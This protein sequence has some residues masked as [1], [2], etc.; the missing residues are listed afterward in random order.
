[1]SYFLW[2]RELKPWLLPQYP[3]VNNCVPLALR[4]PMS[5]EVW[6]QH[7][8]VPPH[9]LPCIEYCAFSVENTGYNSQ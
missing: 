2:I 4:G 9:L 3:K 1:M 5:P 7:G 6:L 8:T